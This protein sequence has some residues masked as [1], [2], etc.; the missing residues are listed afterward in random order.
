[1]SPEIIAFQHC[2]STQSAQALVHHTLQGL[3]FC[4]IKGSLV[5]LH[6]YTARGHS[7]SFVTL[8]DACALQSD[9]TVRLCSR[10]AV[11]QGRA[12]EEL[13]DDGCLPQANWKEGAVSY[14][15]LTLPTTPYV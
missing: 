11:K 6:S 4:E 2:T 12:Q 14:T 9:P 10:G 1:M 8:D 13:I 5:Q 15:H 7:G 3:W